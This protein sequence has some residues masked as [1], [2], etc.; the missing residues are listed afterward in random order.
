M[1]IILCLHVVGVIYLTSHGIQDK[2][3]SLHLASFNGHKEVVELLLER[4][5]SVDKADKV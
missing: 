4:G 1:I 5:A 2:V 3:T